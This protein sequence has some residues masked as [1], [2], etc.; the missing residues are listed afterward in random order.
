KHGP[1]FI[2]VRSEYTPSGDLT[3]DSIIELKVTLTNIGQNIAEDIILTACV[4]DN[5][6]IMLDDPAPVPPFSNNPQDTAQDPSQ[7]T[8]PNN[9]PPA[10]TT[11]NDPTV[12]NCYMRLEWDALEDGSP[13][14]LNPDES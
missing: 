11:I 3:K 10:T 4:Q 2:V 6:I 8:D 9:P 7:P 13:I 12:N 14:T 1:T 5:Y